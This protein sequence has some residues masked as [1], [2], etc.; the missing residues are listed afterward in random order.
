M[1]KA[2]LKKTDCATNRP[3]LRDFLNGVPLKEKSLLKGCLRY[4]KER[5]AKEMLNIKVHIQ[6]GNSFTI[7]IYCIYISLYI[8]NMHIVK[9]EL[10][11]HT[12]QK[13]YLKS[14]TY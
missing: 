11:C 12:G 14:R 3:S 6:K 10:E 9:K 5:R 1:N 8:I 4:K 13:P 7:V 2:K